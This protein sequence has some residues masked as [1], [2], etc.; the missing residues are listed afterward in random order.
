MNHATL[1]ELRR[2]HP[3][4]RLLAA[5]NAPFVIGFFFESFVAPNVRTLPRDELQRSLEDFIERLRERHGSD[6]LPRRPSEYLE[7]WAR[8]D[9]GWLRKY[10]PE[11][12]GDEPHFDITPATEKAIEWVMSLRRRR[13]VGTESRLL[14]VFDLLRQI[15]DG[16]EAD[17]DVRLAELEKRRAQLDAEIERVRRGDVDIMGPTQVR[18]RFLQF[19][20]TA[21][22][23]LADFR[24][25][26]Q[27]FRELD[28]A[29]R[30]RIAAWEGGKGELLEE[31]FGRRDAIRDSDQ[32]RSFHAFWDLLMAPSR[33][34]ELTTML[35]KVLSLDALKELSPDQGLRR[36]HYDW[37]A[38][39]EVAQRMVARLSQQLRRY[40]DDRAWLENRRIMQILRSVEQHALAVRNEPPTAVFMEIDDLAPA[41]ALPLDRPM[42]KASRKHKVTAHELVH[43]EENVDAASLYG[44]VYVDKAKL[45]AHVRRALQSHDQVTLS[46][47]VASHPLELGLA[48]LVAYFGIAA[49]DPAHAMIDES[50]SEHIEWLDLEGRRRVATFPT[51]LFLRH[52]RKSA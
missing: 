17:P 32:G 38:A 9:H 18:D 16:V 34:D 31:I 51:V 7:E 42:F 1:D 2:S 21:R 20:A 15:V 14:T 45:A 11:G 24:E 37:L 41:I 8:D 27:N 33:Q 13:F 40:L 47:V 39:G 36:I 52:R 35:E 12:G 4:W 3:A 23:L 44:Q 5:A 22:A 19:A 29:V 28:R 6:V 48:E 26:E 50:R 10:Y 46:E 43:G 49:D 30:E 25:V